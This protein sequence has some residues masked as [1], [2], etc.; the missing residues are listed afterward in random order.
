MKL[1]FFLK[2]HLFS[3]MLSISFH[4]VANQFVTFPLKIVHQLLDSVVYFYEVFSIGTCIGAV[5]L[6]LD[7]HDHLYKP[8]LVLL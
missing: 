3:N 1:I 7:P 6:I 2:S 5:A 4:A 8:V